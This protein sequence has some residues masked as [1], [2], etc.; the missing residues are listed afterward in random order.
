MSSTRSRVGGKRP[1][2][3][4]VA[5]VA[6]VSRTTVS[7]VLTGREDSRIS[8][9][10]EQRVRRAAADL[11]YRPNLAARSLR[12]ARSHTF[13]LL[14][15]VIASSPFAGELIRGSSDATLR[16]E[17]LLLMAESEGDAELEHR[18]FQ[19]MIDRQVDGLIYATMFT[20]EAQLPEHARD[21]PLVLLN[22]F[23]ADRSLPAVV[24]DER[25]AGRQAARVLLEAGHRDG[26]IL[27]GET[28]P[29]LFAGRERVA[30]IRAGL[31]SRRTRLA[32][33]L[34]CRWESHDAYDR[35]LRHLED[36]AA[37]KALICLNDRIALGAYQALAAHG[38]RIPDD[39]SVVSFDGSDLASWLV[40]GLTTV[41]IPHYAMGA[42][43]VELLA[44]RALRPQMV[45][46]PMPL[47]RRGS[48]GH[49]SVTE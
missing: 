3:A 29:H 26:I 21:H 35:L 19:D 43:A 2:Q 11:D 39:V 45:R 24:P 44:M 4:D 32:A 16:H 36:S 20:R 37:P 13:G 28:A 47:H 12:T 30:G 10:V 6:Q 1:T 5:R 8:P 17:H 48:V 49:P 31:R 41:G 22:C 46:V 9:E 15:D 14:S 40:P 42:C 25:D 33:E 27:L 18:L 23:V 38:L 34:P 7:F